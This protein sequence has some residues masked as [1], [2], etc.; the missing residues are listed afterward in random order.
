MEVVF[1]YHFSEDPLIE[2]FVPRVAPTQQV[3]GA[4]VWADAAD[5]SP[6]YWF[7]RD[8]PRAAWWRRDGSGRVH[9]IQWEWWDRFVGCDLYVYRFDAAPFRPNPGGGGWIST[10]AV[11]PLEV[12]PVG[13]LLARHREARIEL[14]LVDDLWALWLRVIELPDV[15]FSGIR[16]PNLPQ[17]PDHLAGGAT[18]G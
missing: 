6:R 3:S 17:H 9:A 15:D 11:V 4:Y 13:P 5:T 16:L 7:P 12:G 1:L 14:R 2:V 18:S 10:E 8:C